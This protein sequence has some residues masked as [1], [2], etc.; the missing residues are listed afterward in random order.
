MI[1]KRSEKEKLRSVKKTNEKRAE[2]IL[3]NSLYTISVG[4]SRTRVGNSLIGK[5][6]KTTSLLL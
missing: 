1:I 6:A 4:V 2:F 3:T 5:T